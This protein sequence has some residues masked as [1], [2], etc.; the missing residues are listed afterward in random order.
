[1][2]QE[3]QFRILCICM[4][5]FSIFNLIY[6]LAE[7][8][9]CDDIWYPYLV[10]HAQGKELTHDQAVLLFL[11]ITS[12]VLGLIESAL[13]F[14][15]GKMG[16]AVIN[17][18]KKGSQT[19]VLGIVLLTIAAV[20]TTLN[21]ALNEME[22]AGWLPLLLNIGIALVYYYQMEKVMQRDF[23]TG[24]KKDS[25]RRD[26]FSKYNAMHMPIPIDRAPVRYKF[27]KGFMVPAKE[28]LP[29][30]PVVEIV[31]D[32]TFFAMDM[33]FD[34]RAYVE[35]HKELYHTSVYFFDDE[36]FGA[37]LLPD[38]DSIL[39]TKYAIR[40]RIMKNRL[41]FSDRSGMIDTLLYYF[42]HAAFFE[43]PN[44]MQV[45]I[46][47]LN[48]ITINDSELF[49]DYDNRLNQ[50][51]DN[52][53]DDA[54]EVPKDFSDFVLDSKKELRAMARYYKQLLDLGTSLE[55]SNSILMDEIN[56]KSVHMVNNRIERLQND[57]LTEF[58][59]ANQILATY[60][61]KVD[62]RANNI[63]QILT[64]VTTI[65]MPLTLIT[66]WY[67]MNLQMPETAWR[68]GYLVAII[69]SIIVIGVECI[70]FK[71]K[72]WF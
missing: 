49:N 42:S 41:I 5:A 71:K 20:R 40:Y 25:Y 39:D 70:I 62:A 57:A 3:K 68:Y 13:M 38:K 37:L 21:I 11:Y 24:I 15:G 32:A 33:S 10:Q 56:D 52:I 60:Q 43:R 30:E 18:T 50:L 4:I 14:Y 19:S 51:E 44:V 6:V 55:E 66:G 67:G 59:Y 1:M 17:G 34:Q 36:I 12:H 23:W 46:D 27:E 58:D 29:D 22:L 61:S 7:I 53:A 45:F 28:T 8:A 54:M 47:F 9:V 63:M 48:Y 69:G 2:K 64:I 16:L 26:A 72:K 65:F 31:D 35:S